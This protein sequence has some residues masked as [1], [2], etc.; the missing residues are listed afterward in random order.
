VTT[1]EQGSLPTAVPRTPPGSVLA[2]FWILVVSAAL[3]IASVA[4]TFAT[5]HSLVQE[6]VGQRPRTM[7]VAQATSQLHSYLITLVVLDIAFTI[8]YVALGYAIRAG[9][10][11]AR[12]TLTVIVVLSGVFIL[13]QGSDVITLALLV[14]ALAAV[15]LLYL[16]GSRGYFTR[17]PTSAG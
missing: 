3:H 2:S 14:I 1:S 13:F 16:P 9:R 17:Q 15:V 12:T 6:G 5:W 4:L 10:N 7:S 8:V 11:W